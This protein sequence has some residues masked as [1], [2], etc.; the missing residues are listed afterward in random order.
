VSTVF[1]C[2]SCGMAMSAP[3]D[4]ALGDASNPLC[5]YCVTEAGELQ[6]FEERFE[7]M[8]QWGVRKE[9]LAREMAEQRAREYMRT[10]PA[11]RDHPQL[12]SV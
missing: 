1:A 10:M 7:R 12:R 3:E 9:G 4:H 2:E 11:W 5:R 6:P 8:V